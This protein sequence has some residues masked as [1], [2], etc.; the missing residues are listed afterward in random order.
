MYWRSLTIGLGRARAWLDGEEDR[1]VWLW[2]DWLEAANSPVRHDIFTDRPPG[3]RKFIVEIDES[4]R[5]PEEN[6]HE[7]RISAI[8]V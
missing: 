8:I 7:F 2:G 6:H 4:T 1:F 5:D 3:H